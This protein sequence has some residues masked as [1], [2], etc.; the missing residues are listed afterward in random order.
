MD[1]EVVQKTLII[2]MDSVTP[3]V[4]DL[5][6]VNLIR[7]LNLGELVVDL[8]CSGTLSQMFYFINF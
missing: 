3:E 4:V 6:L 5:D 2:L 7:I 8:D 1:K